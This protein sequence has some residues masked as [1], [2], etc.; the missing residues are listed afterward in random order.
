MHSTSIST[1][2]KQCV[3]FATLAA[4]IY[5][6]VGHS[7]HYGWLQYYAS[8][9]LAS[10]GFALILPRHTL[11]MSLNGI[12]HYATGYS[13]EKQACIDAAKR[14]YIR[15]STNWKPTDRTEQWIK[16]SRRGELFLEFVARQLAEEA[17]RK[18]LIRLG[19]QVEYDTLAH[20]LI[21]VFNAPPP[22]PAGEA[23]P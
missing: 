10:C 14:E 12:Q 5:T 4:V 17:Q 23:V 11:Y 8:L 7:E 22:P 21:E 15:L 18:A 6:N 16:N 19:N 1:V 3:G 2:I 13:K 9:F 20:P